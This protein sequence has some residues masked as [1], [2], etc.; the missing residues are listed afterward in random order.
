LSLLTHILKDPKALDIL[1]A[2]GIRYVY[3]AGEPLTPWGADGYDCSGFVQG[4]LVRL[5]ILSV[6]APD[7][8]AYT[9]AMCSDPVPEG[10][11]KLGDMA[12]YGA[13]VSHVM[14]V[15]GKGIVLGARGGDS[16]THGDNPKA[17][18]DLKRVKKSQP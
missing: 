2:W 11:E 12:F 17:Y 4:A 7:R 8:R 14:L 15:L 10:E 18:V 13:P 5:G 6:M 9:L 3:G 16:T 1:G